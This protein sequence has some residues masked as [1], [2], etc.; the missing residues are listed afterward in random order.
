MV[1]HKT[2]I[3]YTRSVSEKVD[4]N[5]NNLEQ[6]LIKVYTYS[7]LKNCPSFITNTQKCMNNFH[8]VS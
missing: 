8:F 6:E 4:N 3:I 7:L 2:I 1:A 5:S